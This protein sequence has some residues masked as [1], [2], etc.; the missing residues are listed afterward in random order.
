MRHADFRGCDLR[1]ANLGGAKL[2]VADL[3]GANLLH[4]GLSAADLAEVSGLNQAQLDKALGDAETKLP[5]G[6]RL[7]PGD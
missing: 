5:P 1:S 4:T 7:V 2:A 6:L 3:T